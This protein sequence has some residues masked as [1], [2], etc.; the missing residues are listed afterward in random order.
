MD[1]GEVEEIGRWG[2]N[3]ICGDAGTETTE[4]GCVSSVVSAPT[5]FLLSLSRTWLI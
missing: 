1:S 5:S 4:D 3:G 2:C